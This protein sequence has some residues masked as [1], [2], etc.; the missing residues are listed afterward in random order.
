M[1][2]DDYLKECMSDVGN[3]PLDVFN[4]MFCRVCANRGCARSGLNNSAF[5]IRVKNWEKTLFI[6]V[7]RASESDTRYDPIRAKKFIPLQSRA[8]EIRSVEEVP[9]VSMSTSNPNIPE[10]PIKSPDTIVSSENPAVPKIIPGV[11]SPPRI[12]EMENTPFNQGIVLPGGSDP[13]QAPGSTFTFGD[14]G[15]D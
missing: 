7:P 11:P 13:I 2:R 1:P 15:D 10:P 6:D 9:S 4:Q 12:Q 3:V 5:D 8:Y 14:G